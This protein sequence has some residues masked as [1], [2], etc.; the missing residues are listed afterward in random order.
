VNRDIENELEEKQVPEKLPLFHELLW[1]FTGLMLT[2]FGTF[3][4]AFFIFPSD[5]QGNLGLNSHSLGVTFQLVGVLLTGCLGGQNAAA[6][7]QIAYVVLGLFKL[8]VFAQGGGF[9]YLQQPTFG[10]ILGFIPGAWLCGY[11]A[12]P[13]KRRLESLALSATCGLI[14]IHVI[15]I[16]YLVGFSLINPLLGNSLAPDYLLKS[17]TAYSLNPL[18]SH[19]VIVC[20]VAMIAYIIRLILF[21]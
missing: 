11:L 2:I 8:P 19:L 16:I 10:Y 14:V 21:Y 9:D 3:V 7:A 6:F 13:G 15:G 18:P 17:L 4:E 5:N 1:A 12:L 20:V